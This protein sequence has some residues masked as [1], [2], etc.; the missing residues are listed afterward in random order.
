MSEDDG[1]AVQSSSDKP[2]GRYYLLVS[3]EKRN[4]LSIANVIAILVRRRLLICLLVFAFFLL[5]LVLAVL[6]PTKYEAEILLAETRFGDQSQTSTGTDS[7]LSI[8]IDVSKEEATEMF[9]SRRFLIH[10]IRTYELLPQLFSKKWDSESETW[11]VSG[12]DIPTFLDGYE[13]IKDD[14]LDVATDA[15]TGLTTVSVKWTDPETATKWVTII[16]D[17]LNQI[18]RNDALTEAKRIIEYLNI[19][20]AQTES[21][22][23][24]QAL[25]GQIATQLAR[26]AGAQ[27]HK[28]YFFR[29]LDPA[30]LPEEPAI[31]YLKP[32]IVIAV[33]ILG[34]FFV[35]TGV[36][37]SE[38]VRSNMP[39]SHRG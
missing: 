27:V 30:V 25:Y 31:K 6:V 35:V 9:T 24:R 7:S 2:V 28:E 32:I 13:K 17:E 22:D 20:I 19:Q 8:G 14:V 37:L 21:L 38:T 12:D 11:K 5:G 4:E 1:T 26:V 36:I 18:L 29:T 3:E 23:I 39:L 15:E 34:V 10:V 33:T 16:V